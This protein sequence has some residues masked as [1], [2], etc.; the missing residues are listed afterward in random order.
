MEVEASAGFA[1]E[2][3][4]SVGRVRIVSYHGHM[5]LIQ[6]VASNVWPLIPLHRITAGLERSP[7]IYGH[8]HRHGAE[9]AFLSCRF[10]L[11]VDGALVHLSH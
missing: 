8:G 3:V 11:G 9:M 7:Q 4:V 6:G 10:R 2:A 5:I 1:C